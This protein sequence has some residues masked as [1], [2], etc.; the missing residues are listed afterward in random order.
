MMR[1]NSQHSICDQ[2]GMEGLLSSFKPSIFMFNASE[3]EQVNL[4]HRHLGNIAVRTLKD[5][6]ENNAAHGLDELR[7]LKS[8]ETK[9]SFCCD[10]KC[11]K[12]LTR[13]KEKRSVRYM[14]SFVVIDRGNLVL[15]A[16]II[17]CTGN[18][19]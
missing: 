16:T 6:S 2:V 17:I 18:C 8:L 7:N 1:D 15:L 19:R 14:S 5:M 10:I 4:L 12:Y 9:C 3:Y 13:K 11:N